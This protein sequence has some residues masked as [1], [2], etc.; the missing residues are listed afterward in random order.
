MRAWCC[1]AARGAERR[2]R[3]LLRTARRFARSVFGWPWGPRGLFKTFAWMASEHGA[4]LVEAAAADAAGAGGVP[5]PACEFCLPHCYDHLI[6]WAARGRRVLVAAVPRVS[7][8]SVR[9]MS[10]PDPEDPACMYQAGNVEPAM[11]TGACVRREEF[12]VVPLEAVAWTP[13]LP[14]PSVNAAASR[15]V[16]G[17]GG[18]VL[19]WLLLVTR[20]PFV[21]AGVGA[22]AALA[23]AVGC[24]ALWWLRRRGS[25]GPPLPFTVLGAVVCGG[26]GAGAR[27][28]D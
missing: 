2:A 20:E 13:W 14:G 16:A 11:Y 25:D 24:A 6:E 28:S 19:A 8:T 22:V 3:E 15:W 9:G 18:R 27:K 1:A 26:A 17:H 23:V 21:R 7:Q 12:V 10:C 5:S 4:A